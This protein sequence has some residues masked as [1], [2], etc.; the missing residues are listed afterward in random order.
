L[1]SNTTRNSCN[2]HGCD[3]RVARDG[4]HLLGQGMTVAKETEKETVY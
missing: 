4:R 2:N 1:E 3:H